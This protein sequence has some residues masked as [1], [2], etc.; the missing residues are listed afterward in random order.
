MRAIPLA[1]SVLIA[2]SCGAAPAVAQVPPA[3]VDAQLSKLAEKRRLQS[4]LA[5]ETA[6]LV[7]QIQTQLLDF[8]KRLAQLTGPPLPLPP[9]P[10]DDPLKGKLAAAFKA[11]PG[12][13]A[14]KKLDAAKLAGT[15]SA[16]VDKNLAAIPELKTAGELI[17]RVRS[18]DESL[19]ADRLPGVRKLIAA[20]LAAVFKAHA[21][22][23]T[24]DLRAAAAALF[25]RIEAALD[26]V[27]K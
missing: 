17:E 24:E 21:T 16:A 26:D 2:M 8:Q 23:L 5:K 15:Y 13:V 10:I 12:D 1:V 18:L 3:D 27:N 4:D 25:A 14:A 7:G 11:D 6:E 22:P 20:E 19:P 9:P